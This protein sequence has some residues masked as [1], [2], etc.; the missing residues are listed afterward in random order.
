MSTTPAGNSIEAAVVAVAERARTAANDLALVHR[1]HKDSA[2]LAMAAAL[3]GATPE[4]LAANAD[5]VAAA[6]AAGTPST[7]IDR[8]RLDEA[9]VAARADG[10]RDVAALPD[11]VGEVVRGSTLA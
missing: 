9:P 3:V 2:L 1:G 7:I 4:V 6:E 8:L 10:L 5:D 11:P